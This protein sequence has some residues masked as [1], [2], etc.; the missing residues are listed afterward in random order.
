MNDEESGATNIRIYRDTKKELE[1]IGKYGDTADTI[2]K[3]LIQF[4]NE[5]KKE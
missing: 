3:K 1:A 4:Y 5:N 2:I